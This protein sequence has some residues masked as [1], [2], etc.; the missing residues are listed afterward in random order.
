MF[1]FV[2]SN[3]TMHNTR[4]KRSDLAELSHTTTTRTTTTIYLLCLWVSLEGTY[5]R[6]IDKIDVYQLANIVLMT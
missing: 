2:Y 6:K 1:C 4:C 5:Y 3:T